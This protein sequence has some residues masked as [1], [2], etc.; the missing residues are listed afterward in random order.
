MTQTQSDSLVKSVAQT[1]KESGF[2]RKGQ[3]WYLDTPEVVLVLNLQRS[4]FDPSF[5]LNLAFWIKA[6]SSPPSIPPG[7][8]T[9]H[10]RMRADAVPELE[11]AEVNQLLDFSTP[12]DERVRSVRIGELLRDHIVPLLKQGSSL[13]GLRK[14]STDGPLRRAWV[15][16]AAQPYVH[17]EVGGPAPV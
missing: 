5:F 8:H 7:E 12:L 9:C 16:V 14:L 17:G 2:A 3:T 13:V 11:A 6:I 10:V 4:R 15:V 1:M